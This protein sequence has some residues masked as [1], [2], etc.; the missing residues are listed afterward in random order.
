MVGDVLETLALGGEEERMEAF[1]TFVLGADG[2]SGM[3]LGAGFADA[4]FEGLHGVAGTGAIGLEFE[5]GGAGEA[6]L[7]G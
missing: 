4:V 2:T 5:V 3:F 6:D 7:T 1:K